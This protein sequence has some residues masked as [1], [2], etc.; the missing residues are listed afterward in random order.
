[1]AGQQQ[2]SS[3]TEALCYGTILVLTALSHFYT[4]FVPLHVNITAFS[5]CI[6]I[7]GANRSVYQLINEFRVVHGKKD[8]DSK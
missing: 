1:M 6:I 7:A 8:G 4:E 2:Y 3:F 5:L